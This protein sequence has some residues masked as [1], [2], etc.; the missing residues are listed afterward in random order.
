MFEYTIFSNT[1]SPPVHIY[2]AL[3]AWAHWACA[4]YVLW[5]QHI[6][7]CHLSNKLKM[8]QIKIPWKVTESESI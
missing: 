8:A 3:L 4:P 1:I 5:I 6:S 2:C 7:A